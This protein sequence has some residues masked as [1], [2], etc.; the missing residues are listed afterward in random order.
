MLT[1]SERRTGVT[2][3][4]SCTNLYIHFLQI[5][6]TLKTVTVGKDIP[7]VIPLKLSFPR[8]LN[9]EGST[10]PPGIGLEGIPFCLYGK[11]TVKVPVIL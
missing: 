6:R 3:P 4:L 10:P 9:A 2:V 5:A 11:S 8:Y 1:G 7:A